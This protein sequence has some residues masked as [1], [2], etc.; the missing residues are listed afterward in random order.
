MLQPS[1][2]V[3]LAPHDSLR[4]SVV[5]HPGTALFC[6]LLD[7]L[8]MSGQGVPSAL[9]AAVRS[10]VPAGDIGRLETLLRPYGLPE[11]LVPLAGPDV[12]SGLEQLREQD[13]AE[14]SEQALGWTGTTHRAPTAPWSRLIDRPA[15]YVAAFARVF[16]AIWSA[17]TAVWQ[18]AQP[19]LWRETE[20]I[21]TAAVTG[22]LDVVLAAL[23]NPCWR[24]SGDT[25]YC[26]PLHTAQARV[27][28]PHR[29]LVLTPLACGSDTHA[30]SPGGPD[31]ATL[32]YP[33]PGLAL[34]LAGAPP[35]PAGDPLT[36]LLGHA[37][38][39]ILRLTVLTPTMAEI[40]T[41]LSCSSGT[42][43][44][45]CAFLES[46]GLLTRRRRGRQ[47]RLHLTLRGEAL[48]DL[49]A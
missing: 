39:T 30:I 19:L 28:Q 21:G 7:L 10:A 15:P 41:A 31:G 3:A 23:A 49:P 14:V 8:G 46:A 27:R 42:A 43:T 25:L 2:A 45:H 9:R 13:L 37:R 29:R 47:V 6:L 48:L 32:A 33:A 24:V 40:A 18:R 12:P 26:P 16:S 44:Y 17:Y 20:R 38:A 4:V 1:A 34:A 11:C 5:H 22:S 35:R 36:V